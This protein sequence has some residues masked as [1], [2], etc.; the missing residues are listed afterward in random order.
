M[1]STSNLPDSAPVCAYEDR[2]EV[3]DDDELWPCVTR[4]DVSSILKEVVRELGENEL[5]FASHSLRVGG[6]TAMRSAGFSDSFIK[7]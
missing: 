2:S 1:R 4:K 5:D 7:W 3:D 6:A